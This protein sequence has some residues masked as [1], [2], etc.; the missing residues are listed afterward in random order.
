MSNHE[1]TEPF[2]QAGTLKVSKSPN[3][4]AAL[5]SFLTTKVRLETLIDFG[6]LRVFGDAAT[7]PI[8]TISSKHT[9]ANSVEYVQ[10]KSL[11]FANLDDF[12]KSSVVKLPESA[13][14]GSNWSLVADTQQLVLDKIK[15]NSIPLGEY[16]N[17]KIRRGILT[18]FNEAFIIDQAVHDRLV[19]ED[20]KSVEVIKPFLVGDDVRRYSLDYR[21]RYLIWTYI[22]IS[23][24]QYPTIYKHLQQYQAQLEKRW[25]KGDHWW[26]LRHCDYY[27]DFEKPKII[28]PDMSISSKFVLDRDGYYTVNT[29]YI[30]PTNDTYL[31]ALMNSYLTWTYLK[32]TCTALGDVDERGRLRMFS[33]FVESLPIRR[34]NFTLSSEQR[35]YYLE[36]AKNLYAY[37]LDKNDQACVLGFVDHHL[38]Q[39]PEQSDVVH[40][41]LAFLAEEMIRL[42]KEKRAAQKQFLDQLVTTLRILLDKEGRKGIDVLTG[43]GKLAD[44]PGDY[45]KGE[46]H[47]EFGELHDILLKNKG[48][49]GVSLNDAGLVERLRRE[50]EGSLQK[51]LP[52]KER[53]AKTDALIDV[54]VYQLYGL[55]EE[56][57]KV[58][59]GKG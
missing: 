46:P 26:E 48:R 52:L 15:I 56:E 20:P 7:D 14:S 18:G 25:D 58:V 21:D 32:R 22:G 49:L 55:T 8:I 9:S 19:A 42:N 29:T 36:K 6:E 41:L 13:F 12:V 17:G 50:Y 33:I 37:C 31:L 39:Q 38:S 45:Q 2:K 16:A 24:N 11:D 51:V 28:Y 44:Y 34:I 1:V 35:T 59:E 53:L 47:L 57:I 43:K 3:Y 30:I 5:R 10:V 54:V 40:D 27:S 4:G 23:I